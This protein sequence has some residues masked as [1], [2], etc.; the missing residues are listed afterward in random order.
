MLLQKYKNRE[1]IP[2]LGLLLRRDGFK[3]LS[4]FLSKMIE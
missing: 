3:V 2:V 4:Q 1:E